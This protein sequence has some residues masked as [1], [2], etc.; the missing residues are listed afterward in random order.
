MILIADAGS[1]KTSWA[2]AGPH[3]HYF[4]TSGIN[5]VLHSEEEI[6][7]V[8]QKGFPAD[9]LK[10][11][12]ER[13]YFFGAG[14]STVKHKLQVEEGI[15][16]VLNVNRV[17]VEH[18]MLG[19]CIALCKD[20]PGIVCILGT[21]SNAC[22]FDGRRIAQEVASPG[23]V[24]ADEGGGVHLGKKLLLDFMRQDIPQHLYHELTEKYHLSGQDILRHIYREPG[25]NRY[26]A[27]F[28]K[29]IREHMDTVYCQ[30]LVSGCFEEFY[31]TN[32]RRLE[33]LSDGTVHFT[34]SVA[35]H[36]RDILGKTLEAK[37]LRIGLVIQH[38]IEELV[39]YYSIPKTSG[40]S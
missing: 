8:I 15:N 26:I 24:L 39:R 28:V 27:G 10:T 35:F 23:Y 3:P 12:V 32:I 34:G 4:E 14:C 36:F 17:E 7:E 29:F 2:I 25:P 16:A 13:I 21:G 33:A 11:P 6:S 22:Y 30:E 31:R 37:G 9:L 19:A 18:D 20:S 5:P 38:P 40:H 1:T